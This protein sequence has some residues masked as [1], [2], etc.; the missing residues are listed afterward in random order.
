[1]QYQV[2][3]SK[4]NSNTLKVK[5]IYFATINEEAEVEKTHDQLNSHRDEHF[6]V[7]T[8]TPPDMDSSNL[9]MYS[10][11]S[12][13]VNANIGIVFLKQKPDYVVHSRYPDYRYQAKLLYMNASSLGLSSYNRVRTNLDLMRSNTRKNRGDHEATHLAKLYESIFG[14]NT[15]MKFK[16]GELFERPLQLFGQPLACVSIHEPLSR[17]PVLSVIVQDPVDLRVSVVACKM[18]RTISSYIGAL[19]I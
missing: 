15:F 11:S 3:E 14:E 18:R 16:T 2:V 12:K 1:M 13:N 8:E 10:I 7:Y 9:Y 4:Q 19:K 6:Y 5:R 17:P